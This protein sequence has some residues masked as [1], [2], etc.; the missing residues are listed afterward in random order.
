MQKR[1]EGRPPVSATGLPRNMARDAIWRTA[2]EASRWPPVLRDIGA[3]SLALWAVSVGE[4]LANILPMRAEILLAVP[5]ARAAWAVFGASSA[6]FATLVA[7]AVIQVMA[8]GHP[9]TLGGYS[10]AEMVAPAAAALALVALCV[11]FRVGAARR[12]RSAAALLDACAGDAVAQIGAANARVAR[13]EAEAQAAR[14]E[15]DRA[16]RE[17]ERREQL[18]AGQRLGT[19]ELWHDAFDKARR[20]EGGI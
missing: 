19:T 5:G 10:V 8:S 18:A 14:A 20:Q 4:L 12:E 6:F 2:Q 9:V 1:V 16:R 11:S 7:A 3:A 17:L 13:A 15:L